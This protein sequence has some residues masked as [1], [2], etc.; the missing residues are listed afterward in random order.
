[1]KRI[2]CIRRFN[3][4]DWSGFLTMTIFLAPQATVKRMASRQ[5]KKAVAVLKAWLDDGG[6]EYLS[7]LHKAPFKR[8]QWLKR[9]FNG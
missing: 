6:R 9:M 8:R 5:Q 7:K 4:Q 3:A 2:L 1:M